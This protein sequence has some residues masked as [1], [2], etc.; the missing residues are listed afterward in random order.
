MHGSKLIGR[1][2]QAYVVCEILIY[3]YILKRYQNN[4]GNK[5]HEC[6]MD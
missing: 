5:I 2:K 3:S 1:Y 4:T 6:D